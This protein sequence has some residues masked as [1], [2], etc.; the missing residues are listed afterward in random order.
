[1]ASISQFAQAPPSP[2]DN[3]T[4]ERGPASPVSRGSLCGW[5]YR[6]DC[7]IFSCP[8]LS[9]VQAPGPGPEKMKILEQRG[10]G[11]YSEVERPLEDSGPPLRNSGS[12]LGE[13]TSSQPQPTRQ[14]ESRRTAEQTCGPEVSGA[15][16]H[17]PSSAEGVG[18]LGAQPHAASAACSHCG[19]PSAR[20]ARL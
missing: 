10:S 15:P 18:R 6:G 5:A 3:P 16:E 2:E 9:I 4:T 12:R 14:G 17:S 20:L 1:M 13:P 11:V 8:F 19:G 7:Y